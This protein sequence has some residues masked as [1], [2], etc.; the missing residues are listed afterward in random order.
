MK[1]IILLFATIFTLYVASA[2]DTTRVQVN[3]KEVVKVM[4]DSVATRVQVMD[5]DVVTVI[6]DSL[7]TRVRVG[8]D[9]GIEV[10]TNA[11]GDTVKI[12]LGKRTIKVVEGEEGTSI[13]TSRESR[14]QEEDPE[15]EKFPGSWAGLEI[16]GNMFHQEN[17]SMY[18]L[19]DEGFFDINTPKSITVNLNFAEF[20][21]SNKRKTVALV[22]GMGFSFMDYRFEPHMGIAKDPVDGKII[23]VEL[24]EG[25]EKSKLSVSYLTVPMIFQVATPLKRNG[26][27]LTLG[28]GVIGGLNIGSHT[29]VK[30][31]D[32]KE[33]ERRNFNISPLKYDLTGR[34]GMGDISLFANMGMTSLFKTNKGPDI[35]PLTVGVTFNVD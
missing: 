1:K 13:K 10:V 5:K 31:D 21:F 29:K 16:G 17:Y 14:D 12:R 7:G 30:Y 19:E 22:T 3:E 9:G 2:Q 11:S 18:P 35:R 8:N 25:S 6:E 20:A 33:K 32:V 24:P 23:A 4:E 26:T 15:E 28:A 34:I 27:P